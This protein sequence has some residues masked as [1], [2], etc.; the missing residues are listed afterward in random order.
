MART[1]GDLDYDNWVLFFTGHGAAG[2]GSDLDQGDTRRNYFTQRHRRLRP[3][4][5]AHRSRADAER[6]APLRRL[7]H[8]RR[9]QRPRRQLLPARCGRGAGRGAGFPGARQRALLPARL[10]SAA[11]RVST[12]ARARAIDLSQIHEAKYASTVRGDYNNVA[13]RVGLAWQPPFAPTRGHSRRLGRLLRAHR[14]Q[15]QARPAAGRAVL[16]SAE[17]AGAAEHGRS[18]SAPQHQPLPD[19]AERAHRRG[20]QRRA[21]SG[22]GPTAP[23]SRPPSRSRPRATSSS[24]RCCGRPTCSSGRRACSTSCGA[25]M[26]VDVGYVGSRGVGLLGKINRA[27]PVDPRVTPVNGFTEH[28]RPAR[29]RHQPGLLR[30]AAVPRPQPQRRVPAAHQHRALDVSQP[31]DE[32]ARD[33]SAGRSRRTSRTRSAARWTRCRRTAG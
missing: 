24:T 14:R 7:R 30:A 17:R 28:L 16:R 23:R 5:L 10:R 15:L 13:P 21:A 2:G 27:V 6:G 29:P 18:V 8:L 22:C 33:D 31:A 20:R 11:A 19:S 26:V 1:N 32:A 25:G 12:S 9:A 3:G 4:R